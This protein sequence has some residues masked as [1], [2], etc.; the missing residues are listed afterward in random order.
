[1]QTIQSLLWFIVRKGENN[2]NSADDAVE[3]ASTDMT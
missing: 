3:F 1:M 2:N